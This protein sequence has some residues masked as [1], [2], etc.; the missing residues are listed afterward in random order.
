MNN[1]NGELLEK[2]TQVMK[3]KRYSKNTISCYKNS[4]KKFFHFTKKRSKDISKQD[5]I[6][7]LQ[8]ITKDCSRSAHE[9]FINAWR[10]YLK[11]IHGRVLKYGNDYRPRKKSVLPSVLSE[12]EIMGAIGG[13]GNLK[14]KAM[15]ST[16]FYLGIRRSELLNLKVKDID[17]EN[18]IVHIRMGKGFKDNR[19]PLSESLL[20]LLRQYYIEYNPKL[21]LFEGTSGKYS[22]TSLTNTVRKYLNTNPHNIR[23]SRATN[24]IDN[25]ADIS[26]VQDWLNHKD[27]RTTKIYLHTSVKTLGKLHDPLKKAI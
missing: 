18:M 20:S 7:Y 25:G 23:H 3:I 1:Y 14:H 21:F 5:F 10:M 17:S 6:N 24:L 22:P 4:L 26:H 16:L 8:H 11:E 12:S 2:L 19:L 27:I 13:C 9:Q 15:L